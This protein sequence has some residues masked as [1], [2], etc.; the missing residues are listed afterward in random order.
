VI[1]EVPIKQVEFT[2]VEKIVIQERVVEVPKEITTNVPYET[3]KIVKE[4]VEIPRYEE[5]LVEVL[6][7]I[8]NIK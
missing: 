2:E 8:T 1:Q 5:R 7:E 4:I 3:S 6:R